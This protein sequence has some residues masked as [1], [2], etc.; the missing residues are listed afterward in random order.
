MGKT[1][2]ERKRERL[3]ASNKF[4]SFKQNESM[5]QKIDVQ[6]RRKQ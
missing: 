1:A 3:K 6:K 2:A 4:Q 5:K